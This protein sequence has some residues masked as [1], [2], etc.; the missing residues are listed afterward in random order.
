MGGIDRA[1]QDETDNIKCFTSSFDQQKSDYAFFSLWFICHGENLICETVL[2]V[3]QNIVR[4]KYTNYTNYLKQF[5][6]HR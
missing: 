1:Y 4:Y 3:G 2:Q 6:S 5:L